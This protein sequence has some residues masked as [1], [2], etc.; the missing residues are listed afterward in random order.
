[1]L[2]EGLCG[3]KKDVPNELIV[4]YKDIPYYP[5]SYELSFDKNGYTRHIAILHDLHANSIIKCE[6]SKVKGIDEQ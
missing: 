3:I 5:V 2:K 1:M 4:Y 6:L